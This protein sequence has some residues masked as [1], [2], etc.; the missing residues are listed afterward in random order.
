MVMERGF[1]G[2]F[3]DSPISPS[4]ASVSV[5]RINGS[6]S[7]ASRSPRCPSSQEFLR[8]RVSPRK[9]IHPRRRIDAFDGQSVR[10]RCPWIREHRSI[11]C[12]LMQLAAT[13]SKRSIASRD[14]RDF[15]RVRG[16]CK[17]PIKYS[18]S[19]GGDMREC[20]SRFGD[21]GAVGYFGFSLFG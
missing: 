4:L 2:I 7:L 3:P 6:L 5:R 18:C 1:Y 8:R 11:G 17:W 15:M 13:F 12:S 14:T 20:E 19:R 9:F 10:A 16:A 21:F